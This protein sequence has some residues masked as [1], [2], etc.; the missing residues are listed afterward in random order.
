MKL[1]LMLTRS[2]WFLQ[3]T[4]GRS[5]LCAVLQNSQFQWS[6]P[7]C[8]ARAEGARRSESSRNLKS[9]FVP[10]EEILCNPHRETWPTNQQQKELE[11]QCTQSNSLRVCVSVGL[12]VGS[13]F[14]H[15]CMVIL[16]ALVV[17]CRTALW[18]KHQE[19]TDEWEQGQEYDHWTWTCEIKMQ[20][21]WS[22]T[23]DFQYRNL[24][25]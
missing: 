4:E 14:L 17:L 2:K 18:R 8:S 13:Q 22:V 11:G 7:G 5:G 12:T 9:W 20:S 10:G 24:P 16:T 21:K 6:S 23:Q 25:R 3:F 19:G 1:S 15:S